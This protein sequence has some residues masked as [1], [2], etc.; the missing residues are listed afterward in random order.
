MREASLSGVLLNSYPAVLDVLD[1]VV[2]DCKDN[3]PKARGLLDQFSQGN[4]L[5]DIKI[6]QMVFS[7]T[8]NLNTTLQSKTQTVAGAKVAVNVVIQCLTSKRLDIAFDGV[9]D[10]VEQKIKEMDL[11]KPILPRIRIL[12]KR[13]EQAQNLTAVH[14]FESLKQYYRKSYHEFLDNIIN[15]IE[16]RFEQSGF[17]KYLHLEKSLLLAP[18]SL[19]EPTLTTISAFGIDAAKLKQEKEFTTQLIQIRKSVEDYVNGFKQMHPETKGLF[20]QLHVL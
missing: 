3:G 5:F 14:K 8:E 12:L 2:Y 16:D 18:G 4:V 19:D 1:T 7:L 11:S 10:E 20:P 17:E 15:E 6:T 9:W 13:L